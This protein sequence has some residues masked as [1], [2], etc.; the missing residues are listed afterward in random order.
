[1]WGNNSCLLHLH[2]SLGRRQ[3]PAQSRLNLHSHTRERDGPVWR[4]SRPPASPAGWC[5][6]PRATAAAPWWTR[7]SVSSLTPSAPPCWSDPPPCQSWTAGQ[8]AESWSPSHA[9][10]SVSAWPTPVTLPCHCYSWCQWTL[11]HVIVTLN[12]NGHFSLTVYL[13]RRTSRLR[14]GRQPRPSWPAGRWPSW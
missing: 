9:K 12:V 2:I 1:M 10:G 7:T 5:W 14:R 8:P 11:C 3:S 4:R 13:G 6:T